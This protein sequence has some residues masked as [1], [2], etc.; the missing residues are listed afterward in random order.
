MVKARSQWHSTLRGGLDRPAYLVQLRY[1]RE[2][3]IS[4]MRPFMG[5]DNEKKW[6]S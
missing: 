1:N 4:C 2:A 5:S 3:S 6:P